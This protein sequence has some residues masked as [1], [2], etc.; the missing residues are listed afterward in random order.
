VGA[1]VPESLHAAERIGVGVIYLLLGLFFILRDRRRV[2]LLLR[3]AFVASHAEL[4]EER[5][6]DALGEAEDDHPSPPHDDPPRDDRPDE[7]PPT[8]PSR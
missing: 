6:Q 8:E 4:S 5:L 1:L 3:D 2:P 7:D